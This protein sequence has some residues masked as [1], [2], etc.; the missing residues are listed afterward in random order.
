MSSILLIG[1]NGLLARCITKRL[2]SKNITVH[3]VIRNASQ[4]SELKRLG[5]V[6]WSAGAG[7][8]IASDARIKEVDNEGHIKVID[9]VAQAAEEAGTTRRF[10]TIP[11]LE[12][13][14]VVNKPVPEWYDEDERRFSEWLSQMFRTY[15]AARLASDKSLVERNVQRKLDYTIVRPGWMSQEP[16]VGR[17]GA[18][19]CRISGQ[20]SRED[21]TTVLEICMES[22]KTIGLTFDVAGGDV[23]IEDA[24]NNATDSFEGYY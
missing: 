2:S 8:G 16:G 15:H 17:I 21:V 11:S 14:D 23:P 4:I 22:E 20:V 5:V 24:V 9:A 13:R 18:G 7:A 12:V 19:K 6:I 10:I 3:S 1:G